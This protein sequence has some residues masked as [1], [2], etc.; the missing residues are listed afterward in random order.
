[1]I[2]KRAGSN[3]LAF[4]IFATFDMVRSLNNRSHL[5]RSTFPLQ[6]AMADTQLSLSQN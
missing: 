4:F 6:Q 2:F 1:M 5:L 3:E